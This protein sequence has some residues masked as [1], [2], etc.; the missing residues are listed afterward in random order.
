[1]LHQQLESISGFRSR[2]LSDFSTRGELA[3]YL[4]VSG[5]TDRSYDAP[6][7]QFVRKHFFIPSLRIHWRRGVGFYSHCKERQVF[8]IFLI[9]T[10]FT[11]FYIG[12]SLQMGCGR[13][14]SSWK[15]QRFTVLLRPQSDASS[16]CS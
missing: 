8:C 4:P 13:K 12:L 14:T 9:Q 5:A 15:S 11:C 1:M 10:N 6:L 16:R 3:A 7:L 2:S